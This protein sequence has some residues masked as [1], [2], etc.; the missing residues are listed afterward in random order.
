MEDGANGIPYEPFFNKQK[1]LAGMIIHYDV[2]ESVE[3]RG[4]ECSPVGQEIGTCPKSET[5]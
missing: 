4:D 1:N 5:F 3:T 2:S